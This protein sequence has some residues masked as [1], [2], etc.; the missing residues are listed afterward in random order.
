MYVTSGLRGYCN[1][2][3]S[4]PPFFC[5]TLPLIPSTWQAER[6]RDRLSRTPGP[7]TYSVSKRSDWLRKTYPPPS[8]GDQVCRYCIVPM[9]K[10]HY[11][12]TT[13]AESHLGQLIYVAILGVVDL[14]CAFAFLHRS[15]HMHTIFSCVSCSRVLG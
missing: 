8:P 14:C 1:D 12:P 3:P 4:S 7:G 15:L 13:H 2:I 10:G 11:D 9:I 6:F 5:H